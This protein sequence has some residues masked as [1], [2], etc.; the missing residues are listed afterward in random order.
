MNLLIKHCAHQFVRVCAI[1]KQKR[2]VVHPILPSLT[3]PTGVGLDE[4]EALGLEVARVADYASRDLVRPSKQLTLGPIRKLPY[5]KLPSASKQPTL[6]R[7]SRAARAA[8]SL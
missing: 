6:G 3:G 1:I 7:M 5:R 2:R 8:A 4:A